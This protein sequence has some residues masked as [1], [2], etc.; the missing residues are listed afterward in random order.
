MLD[1]NQPTTTPAP[2]LWSSVYEALRAAILSHHLSPGTK[3]PED[4]I[5]DVYSVSRTVV[6]AALQALAHD[7]LVTL[8][9]K[10]GAFVAQ[11]SKQE[12]RD[13]TLR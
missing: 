2:V 3:L 10:R 7:R 9:P 12:A 6:R 11:P 1:V 5:G 4:E 13:S 8:E